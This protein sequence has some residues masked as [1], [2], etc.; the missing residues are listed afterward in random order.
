MNYIHI[1]DTVLSVTVDCLLLIY[2]SNAIMT[3]RHSRH[4]SN[5]GIIA[6]YVFHGIIVV[7]E[8]PYLNIASFIIPTFVV[9]QLGFKDNI[10]SIALKTVILTI[11]MMFSEFVVAMCFNIDINNEWYL[12]ITAI[13]DL[14]FTIASKLIYC[15]AIITLKRISVNRNQTYKSKKMICFLVLPISTLLFLNCFGRMVSKLDF[16]MIFMIA[17]IAVM[18]II[19][20]FVV[21]L[22]CDRII[23]NSLEIQ[24]LQKINSKNEL[25][26]KS[27]QLMKEKYEDL[28]IMAHDFDKYCNNIEALLASDQ[29]EVLTQLQ[30]IK[31]RNKELLLVEYTNNKALNLLLSQKMQ[32]CNKSG[33]NFQVCIQNVDLSFI[34]EMDV[35]SIFANLIDNAIESSII[36]ENK[37]IFLDLYKMN[38]SFI[39][40]RVDNSSDIEPVVSNG[41]LN[42]WKKNKNQHGIGMISINKSLRKYR[43]KLNWSYDNDTRI[44]TSM[45]LIKNSKKI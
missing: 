16:D 17:A 10:S 14:I 12:H 43:G 23:D 30:Q 39:V 9:L 41:H 28:R 13:G 18:L 38:H 11:L 4:R 24:Y 36:S 29:E 2:Y 15:I 31:N 25:D 26:Y 6:G 8:N 21:Y 37:K 7:F 35:V 45:A 40:V 19:S 5:I 34:E 22:V 33:I 3:Y 27:Y 44:F 32:E 1:F 42:T 20:N